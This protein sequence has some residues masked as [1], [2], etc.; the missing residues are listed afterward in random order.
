MINASTLSRL[1]QFRPQHLVDPNAWIGHTPFAYWII[2]RLKPRV[3]VELGTHSGNSYFSFCQSIHDNQTESKAFAVD[4]WQGDTHAGFYGESVFNSVEQA[5]LPYKSFSTLLRTTFDSAANNFEDGSVD[6]LHIDG[7][8]TYEAVKHDF[9]T[10]LP[11]MSANGVVL[12]HDTNVR[13]DD[14]GVY[15]LWQEISKDYKTLEFFH[16]HGL[17]IL[18][19]SA[20]VS[21]II[22]Q[23][24]V[25]KI[26]MREFF[27]GLSDHMLTRFERDSLVN[28]LTW[29]ATAPIRVSVSWIARFLSSIVRLGK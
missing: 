25:E 24:E 10:W 11:K 21:K 8:H 14:F 23:E 6:L 2:E 22:P 16:S 7:L 29:K 9:E 12:F 26:E 1:A 27:A 3:F 5:N 18:D 13:R 15:R 20:S 17:G 28:S 4:T 19:L